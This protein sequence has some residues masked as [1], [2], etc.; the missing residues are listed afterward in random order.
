MEKSLKQAYVIPCCVEVDLRSLSCI[1]Q[2]PEY[3]NPYEG[4]ENW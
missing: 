4:H 1:A 3:I 2:S